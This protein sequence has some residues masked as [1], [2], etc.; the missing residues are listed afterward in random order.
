MWVI[1]VNKIPKQQSYE[2]SKKKKIS[3]APFFLSGF[4]FL[5]SSKKYTSSNQ[6]CAY[7]WT[8]VLVLSSENLSYALETEGTYTEEVRKA[9]EGIND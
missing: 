9:S 5:T 2:Q 6:M 1:H 3:S 4:V 7:I 8:P